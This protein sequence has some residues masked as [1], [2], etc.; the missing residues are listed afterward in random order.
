VTRKLVAFV[1]LAIALGALFVRLG[2]WQLSRRGERRAANAVIAAQLAR[3][4]ASVVEVHA[5]A[6]PVNRRARVDGIPDT[7]NEFVVTGRS[8][9]GSPGV[10]VFTPLRVAGMDSAVL[11]NRG[12]VYSPDASTVE[13]PRA[14]ERRT[15]FTG[16]T[17]KVAEGTVSSVRGRGMRPLT[18]AGVQ[19]LVPYP[20]SSLYLV[21]QDSAGQDA[22]ARLDAPLLDDGPHLSYAIQW[23]AF[24]TI[25]LV[26]AAVVVRRT[27][28]EARGATAAYPNRD[29]GSGTGEKST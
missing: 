4:P 13:L 14:R 21:A 28:A 23:F 26:G 7:A 24:A 2:L 19:Q 15:S 20:V 12:W 3:A 10:H 16:Y 5:N 29:E 22:P 6:D 9:N 8:R 27:R 17:M 1:A 25:A 18:R 11:V